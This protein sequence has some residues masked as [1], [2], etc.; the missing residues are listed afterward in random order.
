MN[1]PS[2]RASLTIASILCC[3]LLGAEAR[4]QVSIEADPGSAVQTRAELEQL[5][6]LYEQVL[7]SPAYSERVK[8]STRQRAQRITE[9]L[10][11][12]DFRLGDQVVLS[13]RGEPDLPDTVSVQSGPRIA[14]PLFGDI[15]LAGVLR[16]EVEGHITE[17]LAQF[18]RDPVVQAQGLMRLSVQGAVTQPGFY[19]VPADMLVSQTLMIAG[20]TTPTSDI[21]DLR[22]ERGSQIVM[23][24]A[25][26]QEAVR[27]GL[28]LDQLNL[29]A[30]DQVF[31]P[32]QP[33]GGFL[34][35]FGLIVGVLTSVTFV[36]LQ[37]SN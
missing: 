5:L 20:G 32:T 28:T 3:L 34:T 25:E 37:L 13:V 22:I 31:V 21:D 23:E 4:A 29:Q 6:E 33:A 8:E 10:T 12:G 18:I 2:T 36:I 7:A 35:N 9:R 27:Q 17:A 16:S 14:L 26:L 24:G 19:V 15:S 30:G 11:L 1:R